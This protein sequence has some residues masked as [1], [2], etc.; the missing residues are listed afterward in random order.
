MDEDLK[1]KFEKSLR[2]Y[3]S[4]YQKEKN[5]LPCSKCGKENNNDDFFIFEG[6]ALEG[7]HESAVIMK[8][9]VAFADMA[10]HSHTKKS[11]CVSLVENE[12]I[13]ATNGQFEFHFCFSRRY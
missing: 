6:G 1:A 3:K 5:M 7:D 10:F 4:N 13:L 8:K 2:I 12:D 11:V 9:G